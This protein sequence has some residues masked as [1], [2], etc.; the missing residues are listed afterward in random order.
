METLTTAQ[1]FNKLIELRFNEFNED[2][3][4]VALS[5][6][7]KLNLSKR[8]DHEETNFIRSNFLCHN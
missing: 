3:K 1:K 8:L 4:L 2:Q 7:D 5:I 6:M